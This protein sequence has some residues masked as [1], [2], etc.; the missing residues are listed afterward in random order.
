MEVLRKMTMC[1]VDPDREAE[2]WPMVSS[3]ELKMFSPWLLYQRDQRKLMSF[4]SMSLRM[5]SG[6]GIGRQ[7]SS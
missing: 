2:R 6:K 1:G 7:G 4:A 5:S 3:F